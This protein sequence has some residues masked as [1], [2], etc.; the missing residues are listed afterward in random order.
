M[1]HNEINIQPSLNIT[2]F[3]L[4]ADLHKETCKRNNE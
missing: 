4:N 2:D 1:K 3:L